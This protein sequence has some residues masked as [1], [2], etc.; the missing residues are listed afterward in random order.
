M[1]QLHARCFLLLASPGYPV[2]PSPEVRLTCVNTSEFF[3]YI[4]SLRT[5][6]GNPFYDTRISPPSWFCRL[7]SYSKAQSSSALTSL[8][9]F[10]SVSGTPRYRNSIIVY[11]YTK[12]LSYWLLRGQWPAARV[13]QILCRRFKK[14]I[15]NTCM[16]LNKC[17]GSEEL[18][19]E[20]KETNIAI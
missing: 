4:P 14:F 3:I 8:P 20:W 17:Y 9:L 12:V 16:S 15:W 7:F 10:C 1:W 18:P 13:F 11:K 6:G 5:I 19:L 2:T